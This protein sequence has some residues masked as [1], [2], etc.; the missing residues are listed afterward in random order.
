MQDSNKTVVGTYDTRDEALEVVHKLKD[1]GYQKENIILY[2]NE[3]VT[4][5][6]SDYEA[7][8]IEADTDPDTMSSR[9][10][11]EDDQSMWEKI[12]GAFSS[13]TYD[14]DERK[15]DDSYNKQDDMLYPYRD[16]IKNGKVVVVIDGYNGEDLDQYISTDAS[17]DPDS[18]T[19]QT[20][21][22]ISNE[23]TEVPVEDEERDVDTD[24]DVRVEND[25][26]H[27]TKPSL[28]N[29]GGVRDKNVNK[30]ND[31]DDLNETGSDRKVPVED[32]ES[33]I[34]DPLTDGREYSREDKDL[35]G[36]KK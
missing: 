25:D 1:A 31:S 16:D 12:K 33:E 18:Q 24:G 13:D 29:Y 11:S 10:T 22:N 6:Q 20:T 3:D 17:G 5:T 21:P 2:A 9:E 4:K 34:N 35:D 28:D 36:Y 32:N 8:N 26:L 7:V 14:H 27:D 15:Q 23:T 30:D 19:P